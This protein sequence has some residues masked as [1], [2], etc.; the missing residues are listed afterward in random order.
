M[1]RFS[2]REFTF[3]FVFSTFIDLQLHD[4]EIRTNIVRVWWMLAPKN[5]LATPASENGFNP[6][7]APCEGYEDLYGVELLWKNDKVLD[8]PTHHDVVRHYT[9]SENKRYGHNNPHMRFARLTKTND[10]LG[11]ELDGQIVN[12]RMGVD[13]TGTTTP[14]GSGTSLIGKLH[15]EVP[16][17]HVDLSMNIHHGVHGA[18]VIGGIVNDT[19]DYVVRIKRVVDD[20]DTAPVKGSVKAY[21]HSGTRQLYVWLEYQTLVNLA[22]GSTQFNRGSQTITKQ[23]NV[24]N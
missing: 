6:F 7:A 14:W 16:I 21:Q 17:Y 1:H 2:R 11:E 10:M 12:Y 23:L 9:L 18:D 3:D 19:S 24:Q 22:A 13:P 20:V 5:I 4:W 8:L 15:Y